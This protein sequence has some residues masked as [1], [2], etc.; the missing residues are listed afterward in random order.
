MPINADAW[1]T[2]A[3]HLLGQS[4]ATVTAAEMVQFATSILTALHG[5]ESIQVKAFLDGCAAISKSSSG[6]SYTPHYLFPHAKGAIQNAVAEVEGGLITSLRVL[7]AGEILSEL[8]R[9]G[10]EILEEHTESAKN[11][12]AVLIAAAFED[13]LRRM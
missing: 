2:R 8:V 11:V 5:A 4:Q 1:L 7:A 13:L 12:A 10:K 3:K 9:L 6:P